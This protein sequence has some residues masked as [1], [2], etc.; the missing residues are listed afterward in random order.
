MR[1]EVMDM[2]CSPLQRELREDEVSP[3]MAT[4]SQRSHVASVHVGRRQR[5]L[6]MYIYIDI[7][8]Y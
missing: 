6:Y 2:M 7:I 1:V 5:A 4:L 3:E 8:G